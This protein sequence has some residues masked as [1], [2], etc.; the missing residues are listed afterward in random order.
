MRAPDGP[1]AATGDCKAEAAGTPSLRRLTSE[2][3]QRSLK[4]LLG[5]EIAVG[6][7]A[8][9]IVGGYASARQNVVLE[10]HARALYTTLLPE[11]RTL[12]GGSRLSGLAAACSAPDAGCAAALVDGFAPRAWRRPLAPDEKTALLAFHGQVQTELRDD[13]EAIATLLLSILSSPH[14]LYRTEVGA[15]PGRPG[16]ERRLSSR[17]VGTAL[18]Y[19]F[20]GQPPDEALLAKMAGSGLETEA[21]IRAEIDRLRASPAHSAWVG[22]FFQQWTHVEDLADKDHALDKYPDATK[23]YKQEAE[24][25]LRRQLVALWEKPSATFVDLVAGTTFV[26]GPLT[27][28]A[29]RAGAKP[30]GFEAIEA[31]GGRRGAFMS[32]GFLTQHSKPDRP[33]ALERAKFFL[34]Q[35]ICLELPGV[36]ADALQRDFTPDPKKSPRQNFEALTSDAAC[37]ACHNMLNPIGFAFDKYGADG[38]LLRQ[39]DGFPIDTRGRVLGTADVDGAID[40]PEDFVRKLAD[41]RE[42]RRCFI[43][44]W[45]RFATGRKEEAP[46]VCTID[47]LLDTMGK[48]GDTLTTFARHYFTSRNFLF[49][50]EAP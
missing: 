4:T 27:A 46:D 36:P 6:W 5:R 47:R 24:E 14:F 26:A 41:S 22:R 11:L 17:E 10:P 37:A 43:K 40:G 33:N 8:D 1:P 20:W 7:P 44:Q 19:F 23:A 32:V 30:S 3:L 2:E 42:A 39:L 28:K 35:A 15:A 21:Q 34:E 48:E 31:E 38:Q 45:F 25:A 16:G 49:R 9:E 12:V 29:Y 50:Q 18:A 13:R